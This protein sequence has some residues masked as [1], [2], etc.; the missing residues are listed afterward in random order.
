M[1]V[2]LVTSSSAAA[3][4][5]SAMPLTSVVLPAPRSPRSTTIFAGVSIPAR[6]CPS[7]IVSSG[8]WV[9]NSRISMRPETSIAGDQIASLRGL[10]A[11]L[12]RDP[13]RGT[14]SQ[15][16]F[17]NPG[18]EGVTQS[19]VIIVLE[20]DKAKRL[21]G[22]VLGFAGGLQDLR[23]GFHGARFRLDGDLNQIALLQRSG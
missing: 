2:G 5:A 10:S 13:L 3:W 15:E 14:K 17:V 18:I 12:W 20:G 7:A 11:T 1:K 22:P 16:V 21:Q 6:E 19:L 9:M 4:K 8:E 23:H